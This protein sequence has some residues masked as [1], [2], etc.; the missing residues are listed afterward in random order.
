METFLRTNQG[1]KKHSVYKA[2]SGI[3]RRDESVQ[4]APWLQ[5]VIN[6][7]HA[8]HV[9]SCRRLRGGSEGE[10][11]VGRG[12]RGEQ[13]GSEDGDNAEH[14]ADVPG[15][16]SGLGEAEGEEGEQV[17]ERRRRRKEEVNVRARVRVS[18]GEGRRGG[19]GGG[20]GPADA[21]QLDLLVV[22]LVGLIAEA[23]Q[24]RLE[25]AAEGAHQV[26]RAQ[27]EERTW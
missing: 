18:A 23:K 21:Q 4:R 12:L 11:V 13:C 25:L 19:G 7:P 24:H 9:L 17:E 8:E 16:S 27:C 26:G 2:P 22:E 14:R 20:G 6:K 3:N 15:S 1:I 10:R 5:R